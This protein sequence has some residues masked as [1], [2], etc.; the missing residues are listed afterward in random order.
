MSYEK[1]IYFNGN[2]GKAIEVARNTFLPLGF[3]IAN[4]TNEYIELTG[5][6]TY[7]TNGQN[8]L[9]GISRISVART[10]NELSIKAEFGGVWKTVKYLI[11]F[12]ISMSIFFLVLFGIV[13]NKQGMSAQKNLLLALGPFVPWPVLIPLMAIWM[14]SRTSNSLD[15]LLNNMVTLGQQ[16]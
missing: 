12:I 14:K 13:F 6:G 2:T 4:N 16:T 5:P 8:P 3:S 9:V 11:I 15:A 7:W 10:H 1:T